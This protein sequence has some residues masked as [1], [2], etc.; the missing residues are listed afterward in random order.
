M[1]RRD[2]VF[3][4]LRVRRRGPSQDPSAALA[5]RLFPTQ[6]G[7]DLFKAFF[8]AILND[9]HR[10]ALRLPCGG[11]ALLRSL[12]GN[13]EDFLG[14]L[15]LQGEVVLKFSGRPVSAGTKLPPPEA[16][17]PAPRVVF[18][19]PIERPARPLVHSGPALRYFSSGLRSA[20]RH[21]VSASRDH[22]QFSSASQ[23]KRWC[24]T[25]C[26]PPLGLLA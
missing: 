21:P 19:P 14:K 16:P 4:G 1:V 24:P 15:G 26:C 11:R 17:P 23:C 6:A 22:C 10:L 2:R 25:S 9:S 3:P 18:A 7:L 5:G 20:C 13:F 8:Q 12:N